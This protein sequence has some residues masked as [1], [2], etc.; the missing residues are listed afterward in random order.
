MCGCINKHKNGKYNK[1]HGLSLS[2]HG[3]GECISNLQSIGPPHKPNS[4]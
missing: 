4:L 1:I 2:K 3:I